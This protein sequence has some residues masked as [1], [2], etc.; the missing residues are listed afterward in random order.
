MSKLYIVH[1]PARS[2]F[3]IAW[4]DDCSAGVTGDMSKDDGVDGRYVGFALTWERSICGF[5]AGKDGVRSQTALYAG[6]K[7]RSHVK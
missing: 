2:S 3:V 5:R 7:E 4:V 6:L 1:I